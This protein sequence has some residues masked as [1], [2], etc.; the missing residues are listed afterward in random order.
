MFIALREKRGFHKVITIVLALKVVGFDPRINIL[1]ELVNN[2]ALW[3]TKFKTD[4]AVRQL[5]DVRTDTVIIKSSIVAKHILTSV[6]DSDLLIETL[7]EI[8]RE[9][10]KRSNNDMFRQIYLNLVR[11]SNL[12][13]I[14]PEKNRRSSAVRFYES[15]KN[16]GMARNHPSFWTQYAIARLSFQQ[17]QHAI[18]YFETAYGLARKLQN[19]NNI[20]IDNH[21]SRCLL[22]S[23]TNS[24]IFPD[25]M[26]VFRDAKKIIHHQILMEGRAH[27]PYRVAT[28]YSGFYRRYKDRFSEDERNEFIESCQFILGKINEIRGNMK[29]NAYI[30]RCKR[31]LEEI[32]SVT[33]IAI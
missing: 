18:T 33:L 14:L 11:F 25:F 24:D 7:I 16:L 20:Q 21:Y 2:N 8:T 30:T 5:I 19:F 32:L 23:A 10:E 15:L 6:V 1:A 3:N 17:Y 26:G 28:N 4:P 13:S 31:E 12:Q 29:D 22:E 9:S 27:Y